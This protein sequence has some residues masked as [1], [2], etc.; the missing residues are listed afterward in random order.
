MPE[1]LPPKNPVG[2]R[3]LMWNLFATV[4]Y[5]VLILGFEVLYKKITGF[6]LSF[7]GIFIYFMAYMAHAAIMLIF[8]IIRTFQK[9]KVEA[10]AYIS[11]TV[12]VPLVGF[13]VCLLGSSLFSSLLY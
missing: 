12:L 8:A 11:A 2:G 4:V 6:D 10:S 7:G 1:Q 13:G 9:R 5:F 3:I